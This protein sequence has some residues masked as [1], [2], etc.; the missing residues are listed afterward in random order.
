MLSI[1]LNAAAD[2]VEW[3][4]KQARQARRDFEAAKLRAEKA[5]KAKRL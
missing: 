5:R 1:I 3:A 2:V 4:A